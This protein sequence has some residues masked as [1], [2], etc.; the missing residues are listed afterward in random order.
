MQCVTAANSENSDPSVK[1]LEVAARAAI[2]SEMGRA[3]S[4]EE[5]TRVSLRLVE[6]IRI[7]RSW[8]LVKTTE[9]SAVAGTPVLDGVA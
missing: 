8:R 5:W 7:L 1:H 2:A 3:L 6:F 9:Q 4:D